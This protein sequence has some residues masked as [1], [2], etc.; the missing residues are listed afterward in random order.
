MIWLP[1]T[2]LQLDRGSLSPG[3]DFWLADGVEGLNMRE[4]RWGAWSNSAHAYFLTNTSRLTR[5]Q[6][7]SSPITS[8]PVFRAFYQH[9]TMLDTKITGVYGSGG[10]FG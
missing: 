8:H 1:R 3:A 4:S 2:W 9:E 5:I 6:R 10:G 7:E